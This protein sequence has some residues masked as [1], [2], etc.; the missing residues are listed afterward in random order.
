MKKTI[1]SFMCLVMA[2]L[3]CG[4]AGKI[5]AGS[6]AAEAGSAETV[7]ADTVWAAGEH[8]EPT[9]DVTMKQEAVDK[10]DSRMKMRIGETPVEVQWEE[11][12]SAEALQAL[13]KDEPLVIEMSMYG[14]FEQVGAI[15]TSIPRN[16]KQTTTSAGDIVLYSGNQIVV[17]YGSNSWA[18]TRLGK[19]TDKS[20]AELKEL[21][22]S[23]DVT[24]TIS[25]E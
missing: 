16:D 5:P 1:C 7:T 19:I 6:S 25:V 21:L 23:E 2:V 4:C 9:G 18:Y 24:I 11:N 14:G 15:G 3:I 12:E 13:A 20:A 10:E 22:G 8:S 17:F